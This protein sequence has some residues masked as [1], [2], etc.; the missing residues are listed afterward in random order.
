MSI[1]QCLN[2]NH[3]TL[4]CPKLK[5]LPKEI[6]KCRKLESVWIE[7]EELEELPS[8]IG[9]CSELEKLSIKCPKLKELPETIF[10][11]KKIPIRRLILNIDHLA[12]LPKSVGELNLQQLDCSWMKNLE[13]LPSSIGN[14]SNLQTLNLNHC[15]NLEELPDSL[16]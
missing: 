1:T 7:S 15:S 8:E 10:Q 13:R 9:Q 5:S 6:G 2:L 12:T 3:I 14:L 16:V 4:Q 11:L